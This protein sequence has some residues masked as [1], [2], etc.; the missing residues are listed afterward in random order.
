MIETV[1][2]IKKFLSHRSKSQVLYARARTVMPSGTTRNAVFYRPFPAYA[3]HAIGSHIYF[4]D[5]DESIDY[6]FNQSSLIL[7]HKHPEVMRAIAAQLER[8][9]ALGAPTEPEVELAE[10]IHECYPAAEKVRFAGTGTEAIM[11]ALR[12][13]RAYKGKSKIAKFEGQFHGTYD[14]VYVSVNP[15]LDKAGQG[16]DLIAVPECEGMPSS[17]PNDA[18]VLPFEDIEATE[19]IIRK[20]RHE[21]AVLIVEPLAKPRGYAPMKAGFLKR[22]KEI[23]EENDVLLMF[24]E[25][26][27]GFRLSKGGAAKVFH[28]EPDMAVFGKNI[29]GGFPVGAFGGSEEIMQLFEIPEGRRPRIGASGTWNAYPLTMAAGLATLSELDSATYERL[30]SRGNQLRDGMNKAFADAGVMSAV[31]GFGSLF[32]LYFTSKEITDYRSA[33][34]SNPYVRW[35]FDLEMLNRGAFFTLNQGWFNISTVTSA[36]DVRFTIDQTKETIKVI[37]PLIQEKAPELLA[38]R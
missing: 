35:I 12:V 10:K 4:V 19:Q 29:G 33:S 38:R 17:V 25:V 8:G 16:S 5:G 32:N 36:E 9:T 13:A 3:D 15:A 24:D 21:L 34:Q 6:C 31:T 30:D 11:N 14:S 26:V 20:N 28:V 1:G 18:V 27:T 37:R 23:T 2:S 22:L 7:G